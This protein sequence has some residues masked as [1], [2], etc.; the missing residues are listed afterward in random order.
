MP[1]QQAALELD[2]AALAR[3]QEGSELCE[4]R[5]ERGERRAWS[6]SSQ[7][8]LAAA[9]KALARPE[10]RTHLRRCAR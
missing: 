7:L 4:Q 3:V 2:H 10:V 9:A 8:Q 6:S 1:V 5:R